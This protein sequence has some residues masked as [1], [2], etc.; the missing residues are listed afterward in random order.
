MGDYIK[1]VF[2]T[3]VGLLAGLGIVSLVWAAISYQYY[4]WLR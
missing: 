3:I 1:A 4:V 2:I